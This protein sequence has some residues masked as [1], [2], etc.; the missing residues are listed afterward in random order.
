MIHPTDMN[1]I[2][3]DADENDLIFFRK[4]PRQT[5]SS[6]IGDKNKLNAKTLARCTAACCPHGKAR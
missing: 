1:K 5:I 2:P 6:H 4:H 3:L